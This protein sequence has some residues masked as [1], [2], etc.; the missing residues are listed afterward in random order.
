[1]SSDLDGWGGPEKSGTSF[2]SLLPRL[3]GLALPPYRGVDLKIKKGQVAAAVST[4]S[5][6]QAEPYSKATAST[7]FSQG[8]PPY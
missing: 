7:S 2:R 3:S 5:I 6:K 4:L 1:M 8:T